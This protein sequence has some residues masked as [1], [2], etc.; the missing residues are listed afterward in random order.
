MLSL[1]I[2]ELGEAG[3]D[4]SLTGFDEF[5]LGE[6]FAERTQGRTDPQRVSSISARD[7]RPPVRSSNISELSSCRPSRV[8]SRVV[9]VVRRRVRPRPHP[10]AIRWNQ[11]IIGLEHARGRLKRIAELR[12]IAARVAAQCRRGRPHR[13]RGDRCALPP[14]FWLTAATLRAF[15]VASVLAS[16]RNRRDPRI[17]IPKG[18]AVPLPPDLSPLLAATGTAQPF[19]ENNRRCPCCI[20]L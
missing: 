4:L 16:R 14:S 2:G 18:E 1:E 15:A 7:Q 6:L 3:F 10:F 19:L 20:L 12:D 17:P 8:P 11:R 13:I 5:E 9:C